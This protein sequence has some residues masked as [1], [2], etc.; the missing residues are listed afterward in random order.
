MFKSSFFFQLER[1]FV[2]KVIIGNYIIG[3][4][5]QNSLQF[6]I[7]QLE[8]KNLLEFLYSYVDKTV[9]NTV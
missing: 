8:K 6:E 1:K 7:R 5:S 3:N 4:N 2:K 9:D